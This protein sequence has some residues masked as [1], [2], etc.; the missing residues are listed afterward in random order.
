[1]LYS[2]LAVRPF[3]VKKVAPLTMAPAKL[4]LARFVKSKFTFVRLALQKL[5]L[6]KM[7]GS[8]SPSAPEYVNAAA[9]RFLL[10]KFQPVKSS[11]AS[12]IP[13]RLSLT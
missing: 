5:A 9:V 1:M 2:W 4:A 7:E 13:A 12:C 6:D 3:E 10:E 8:A 11:P